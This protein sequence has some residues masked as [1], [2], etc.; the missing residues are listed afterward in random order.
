MSNP[1]LS[2]SGQL[3]YIPL[4]GVNC[5]HETLDVKQNDISGQNDLFLLPF[6]SDMLQRSWSGEGGLMLRQSLERR[7][8]QQSMQRDTA[9]EDPFL[10]TSLKGSFR[11]F[12]DSV[13]GQENQVWY[14]LTVLYRVVRRTRFNSILLSKLMMSIFRMFL[15]SLI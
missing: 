10:T 14:V 4:I 9:A 11:G 15:C 2:Q 6:V 12:G 8:A 1:Q 3:E 5:S 13:F 7:D